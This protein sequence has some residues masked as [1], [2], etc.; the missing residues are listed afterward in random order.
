MRKIIALSLAAATL[1]GAQS[2]VNVPSF[3]ASAQAQTPGQIAQ[4]RAAL[5]ARMNAI[6]NAQRSGNPAAL[7]A[8]TQALENYLAATPLAASLVADVLATLPPATQTAIALSVGRAMGDAQE[9][10]IAN[11]SPAALQ[12]A[13]NLAL[14]VQQMPLAVQQAVTNSFQTAGGNMTFTPPTQV[15]GGDNGGNQ[16]GGNPPA[17]QSLGG[18]SSGGGSSGGNSPN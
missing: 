13:A 15:G 18:N 4:A 5:R 3:V 8:A 10:L 7:A 9:R 12:A 11:G 1:V 6:A 16:Q 14:E 17:Y 2:I